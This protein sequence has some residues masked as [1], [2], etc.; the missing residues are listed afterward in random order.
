MIS[1][2]QLSLQHLRDF[3]PNVAHELRRPLTILRAETELALR[4]ATTE[5]ECREALS[6][7]LQHI[8]VLGTTIQD[9]VVLT[10]PVETELNKTSQ[11][12]SA[13][14]RTVVDGMR[15][16][17]LDS[18]VELSCDVRDEIT[19]EIDSSRIYR[20]IVNLI[21]N[22]VKYNRP[23]GR[24]H[25]VLAREADAAVIAVNDTGMGI[26]AADL[27]RIFDR[28][29]RSA[30]ACATRVHGY[31]LG[32]A[33]ARM[34]AVAH[35]GHIEVTSTPG[36]GSCFR[37]VLPQVSPRSAAAQPPPHSRRA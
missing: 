10:E 4:W 31:G 34:A 27:D 1:R 19:A 7:A 13:L 2:F 8:D 35:G 20:L 32:L 17:A 11:S 37:T 18:D 12:L 15:A 29:Y 14:V 5:Q 28:F 30:D 3:V 26:A 6:H 23:N 21:D 9:L 16:S 24:V 22:A 33:F 36:V 25:V